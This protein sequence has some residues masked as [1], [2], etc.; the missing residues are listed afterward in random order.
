[1]GKR[2]TEQTRYQWAYE[3]IRRRI[4]DGDLS[5]G[6]PL[7]E[8]QLADFLRVSRTPVREALKR[9][10]HEGMV[11]AAP[12]RGAFVAELSLQDIMEIYQIR[13]QLESFAVRVAAL[14]MPA[15]DV[16]DLESELAR[17]A[18]LA[19]KGHVR[20]TF[21][22]DVHLHKRIVEA[23]RNKRLVAILAAL[24][25]QVR[26]IRAMSPRTPGRLEATLR[27]HREIADRIKARDAS[28][29]E[30]AVRRH[31][32]AACENAT[33]L[34]FPASPA[35]SSARGAAAAIKAGRPAGRR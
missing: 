1:M 12:N 2:V 32:R 22:S 19:A 34:L 25:D 16:E 7:S 26:R 5:P 20:E 31:L 27:E 18:A 6:T 9:L 15:A 29:A 24:E 17:A 33:H 8:Y 23:P 21:E 11:R 30:A 10:T 3:E 13:E 14:T 28:G 4:L 35:A